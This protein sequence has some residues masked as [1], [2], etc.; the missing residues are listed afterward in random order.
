MCLELQEPW[1][2]MKEVTAHIG[3]TSETIRKWINE[4]GFP[5]KK[6]GGRWKFRMS[7]VDEWDELVNQAGVLAGDADINGPVENKGV[8]SVSDGQIDSGNT[9]QPTLIRSDCL[10]AMS[11]LKTGSADLILTDPP[12]NLGLFMQNREAG[13]MRMRDNY[14]GTAGWDNLEY[15]QW[16]DYMGQLFDESARVLRRGGAMV[17]FMAVIKVETIVRLAQEH[18]FYYKTTGT[19]HKLN[20]MP[21]NMNLHFINSTESWVY[22]IHG[23]RTG[24]FNNNGKAM[25]DFIETSVTPKSERLYGKHP[26]QKPLVLMEH[27]VKTLTNPGDLVIDPFMGSGSTGVAAQRLGRRFT[28]IELNEIY[29]DMACK[30]M[31]VD[32]D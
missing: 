29:F 27:F 12:Y 18:G 2:G 14:F 5:G 21:R 26:T 17:V 19:W 4:R 30:R 7:E 3:V 24:T 20:P 15:D 9:F 10:K 1:V 28:G 11:T 22:L 13:I 25:H 8:H 32:H 31:G 6:Y 16:V 23:G